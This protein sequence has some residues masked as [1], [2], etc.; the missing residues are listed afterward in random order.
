MRGTVS[1]DP[2]H[3][4]DQLEIGYCFSGSGIFTIDQK[5]LSYTSGDAV[6]INQRESH[7]AIS[8]IGKVSVWSFVYFN[9]QKLFSDCSVTGLP[10][11]NTDT[12]CGPQFYNIFTNQ[13]HPDVCFLIND[14]IRE[15][16]KKNGGYQA[17]VRLLISLL[18]I[19]LMR[20][21]PEN[22]LNKI[23]TGTAAQK[24]LL[25]ISPAIRYIA[26]NYSAAFHIS[27]LA[28]LCNLSITHF[29]KMFR[30]SCNI[31]PQAYLMRYRIQAAAIM[32]RET[33]QRIIDIAFSCGFLSL[34]SFNRAF[35]AFFKVAPRKYRK[36]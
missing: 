22:N 29:R 36:G 9:P 17:I 16:R 1:A 11:V 33:D 6:I 23:K 13:T 35:A 3:Q 7:Q 5:I 12:F 31:A 32:L 24:K 30:E 19:K 8:S 18:L 28:A 21:V 20:T 26:D 27:G 10:A 15:M 14:V 25:R 4:H 34:S 2:P